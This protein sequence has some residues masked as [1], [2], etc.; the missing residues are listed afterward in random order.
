MLIITF[1]NDGTTSNKITGNYDIVAQVNYK[2]IY[3]G[4]LEGHTRGD[5]KN[6]IIEWANQLQLEQYKENNK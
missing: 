2:T 1:H 3:A 5:F 6:L 4:R